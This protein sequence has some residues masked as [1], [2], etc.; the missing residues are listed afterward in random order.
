VKKLDYVLNKA[1][2]LRKI[3]R[4]SSDL[5]EFI[6]A[7]PQGNDRAQLTWDIYIH[8]LRAGIG[9][10]LASLGGLDALVFTAGVGERS[11]VIRQ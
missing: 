5:R 11:A 2:R 3:F 1:S 4:V 6:E 7:I 8:R 10:M 9:S